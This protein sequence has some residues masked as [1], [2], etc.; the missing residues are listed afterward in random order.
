[1]DKLLMNRPFYWHYLD[2]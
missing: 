1:M 2:L